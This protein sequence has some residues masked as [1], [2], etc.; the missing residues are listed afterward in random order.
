MGKLTCGNCQFVFE[1][2]LPGPIDVVVYPHCG[3]KAEMI[4]I[5]TTSPPQV[6]LFTRVIKEG[7]KK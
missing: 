1:R 4:Q 2:N 7:K 6:A 3:R 5:N